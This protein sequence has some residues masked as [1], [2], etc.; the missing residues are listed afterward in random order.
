MVFSLYRACA[1]LQGSSFFAQKLVLFAYSV[2]KFQKS[3]QIN[4]IVCFF[5]HKVTLE[6]AVAG[7]FQLD[8]LAGQKGADLNRFARTRIAIVNNDSSLV[9]QISP[10]KIVVYNVAQVK[11]SIPVLPKKQATICFHKQLSLDLACPQ[12][13]TWWTVVL[14]ARTKVFYG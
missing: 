7:G 8:V 11:Q 3:L 9:F 14:S 2:F 10:K 1:L 13:P 4:R 5:L 12:R 6:L